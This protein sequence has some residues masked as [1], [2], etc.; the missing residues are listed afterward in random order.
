MEDCNE[1]ISKKHK[2]GII[3]TIAAVVI[4]GILA[5]Y[6]WNC[7]TFLGSGEA[8]VLYS[9]NGGV[10]DE[11]L[12]GGFKWIKFTDKVKKFNTSNEQLIIKEGKEESFSVSTADEAIL[13][14]DFQM[15]YSF[16]PE[17]LP[18]T[19][20]KFR[21]MDGDDIIEKRLKAV[22]KAKVSEVTSQYSLMDLYSGNRAPINA[23]ITKYLNQIF[24]DS[25]G[26]FVD[27]ASIIDT[28]PDKQ[29]K[30]AISDRLAAVQEKQKAEAEK[31]TRK[32]KLEMEKAVAENEAE[33]KK[34][35]AQNEAEITKLEAEAGAEAN[36][37]LSKSI[38]NELIKMKE[39]EARL[40]H[41]WVTT[42]GA[43]TVVSDK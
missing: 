17:V 34:I 26:I 30:K 29:L 39:A 20:R 23:E 40:K 32:V 2:V 43:N 7:T 4:V 24:H 18:E 31:E 10:K 19:Y 33:I 8:G 12:S 25:Y 5:F 22:L 9:I 37:K 21:G 35:K 41:G 27:D 36:K 6:V 38:T 28:H 42:Q 14:I 3:G 1:S 16:D 13:S 15:T 11:V